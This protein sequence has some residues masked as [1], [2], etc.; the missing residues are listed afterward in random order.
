MLSAFLTYNIKAQKK[1]KKSK[2]RF[3]FFK[4]TDQ[5]THKPTLLSILDCLTDMKHVFHF[6]NGAVV[7][8]RQELISM[9]GTT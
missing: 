5:F 6:Y 2:P 4:T 8:Q 1:K 3:H 9:K 7:F